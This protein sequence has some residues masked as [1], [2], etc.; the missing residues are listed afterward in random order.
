[1]KQTITLVISLLV[2]QISFS[3][4][5]GDIIITE[6]MNNPKAVTDANGEWFEVYNTTNN[7][8]NLN[9]WTIKDL[10][11]NN[12]TITKDL[13][14]L[15]KSFFT[16]GKKADS[17]ING[18]IKSNYAFS[19]TLANGDDEIIIKNS[20]GLLIDEVQ[21]D[22][23]KGFPAPDGASM[24]L[25]LDLS[26]N[27][28]AHL[29]NDI[30]SNWI[31]ETNSTYGS[32][33]YGTPNHQPSVIL[34]VFNLTEF[35]KTSY[36]ISPTINN[37]QRFRVESNLKEEIPYTL[38]TLNGRCIKTST[39]ITNEE[40]TIDLPR[41]IYVIKLNNVVSEKIIFD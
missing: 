10:G 36:T 28:A 41:G 32:G 9:G 14:L 5:A 39:L 21:Y 22:K 23:G 30:A 33:D 4:K 6:I 13:Y 18:G 8:L 19:F 24:T 34:N 27:F 2:C 3:Q 15:P 16:F 35:N 12:H 29:D 40:T 26:N 20:S 1:M 38:H 7:T 31:T 17:T 37:N 25:K 11:S